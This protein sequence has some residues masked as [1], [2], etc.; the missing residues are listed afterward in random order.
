MCPSYLQLEHACVEC[1]STQPEMGKSLLETLCS[2]ERLEENPF[3][4]EVTTV[5]Q[6][7]KKYLKWKRGAGSSAMERMLNQEPQLTAATSPSVSPR[8][9]CLPSALGH[10][11]PAPLS[12]LQTESSSMVTP[13]WLSRSSGHCGCPSLVGF[14]Y[15]EAA[16]YCLSIYLCKLYT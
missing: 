4:T 5:Y 13:A 7:I 3:P 12:G 16:S 6:V 2:R 9:C 1:P 11:K 8:W 15:L 14:C 10:G